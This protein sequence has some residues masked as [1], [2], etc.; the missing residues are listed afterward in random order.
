[1]SEEAL[2][3]LKRIAIA[4][5]SIAVTN[6]IIAEAMGSNN[7]AP[8]AP[9]PSGGGDGAVADDSDL[10]GEW[11]NPT[12][13][14]DPRERYWTGPSFVGYHYSET[15]PDYLDATAKYLEAVA[16]MSAKD[17]DEKSQKRAKYSAKDA[18]RARG[19]AARLRARGEPNA[20]PAPAQGGGYLKRHGEEAAVLPEGVNPDDIPFERG[21]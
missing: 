1:V 17:T 4:C 3:M 5:E 15:A 7:A 9:A 13:K 8:R 11:G 18:A 19:W 12:I 21:A 6:K 14:Y 20:M 2:V 10:D 16:F